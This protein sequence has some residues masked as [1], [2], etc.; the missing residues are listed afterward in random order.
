MGES[1]EETDDAELYRINLA[2]GKWLGFMVITFLDVD[3]CG[4]FVWTFIDNFEW[5]FRLLLFIRPVTLPF[6]DSRR[7]IKR[8]GH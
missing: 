3:L 7:T 1:A 5:V 6:R 4:Y 2:C 8:S